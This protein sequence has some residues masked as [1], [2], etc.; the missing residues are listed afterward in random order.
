[1]STVQNRVATPRRRGTG[2]D[3]PAMLRLIELTDYI[4]AHTIRGSLYLTGPVGAERSGRVAQRWDTQLSWAEKDVSSFNR[5]ILPRL[6]VIAD[7]R[8]R[9]RH[10][11]SR[12]G[13]PSAARA[14]LGERT[15]T[16]LHEPLRRAPSARE[17]AAVITALEQL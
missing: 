9:L 7:E 2:V 5:L 17:L 15:W 3:M 1:M 10:G 16:L 11:I 4:V 14:L 13:D 12:T 8:L 6:T